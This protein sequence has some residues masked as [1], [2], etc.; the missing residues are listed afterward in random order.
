MNLRA[1]TDGG[2]AHSVVSTSFAF[3]EVGGRAVNTDEDDIDSLH[4]D[5]QI[6]QPPSLAKNMV[7]HDVV[8]C[9]GHTGHR[10]VEPGTGAA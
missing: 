6:M 3:S 4:Y 9:L 2:A 1:L 8:A 7:H 10:T 5:Q